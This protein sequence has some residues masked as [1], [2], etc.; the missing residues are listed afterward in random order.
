ML[1][2][3]VS[4]WEDELCLKWLKILDDIANKLASCV[5]KTK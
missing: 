3:S 1:V 5:E 2:A 4:L